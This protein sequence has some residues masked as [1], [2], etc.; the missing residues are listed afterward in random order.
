VLPFIGI[1]AILASRKHVIQTTTTN[2]VIEVKN[3]SLN[4]ET[5]VSKP[6][7]TTQTPVEFGRNLFLERHLT[8]KTIQTTTTSLF[9][10]TRA[11]Y[12]KADKVYPETTESLKYSS[13]QSS[14]KPETPKKLSTVQTPSPQH[15]VISP[16]LKFDQNLADLRPSSTYVTEVYTA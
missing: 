7:F 13:Y 10:P 5:L 2:L 1:Y 6:T 8:T 15:K 14:K 12:F 3:H 11:G 4:N 9:H 16:K